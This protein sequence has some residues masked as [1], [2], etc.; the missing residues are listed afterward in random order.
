MP[1]MIYAADAR[2]WIVALIQAQ[3]TGAILEWPQPDFDPGLPG[4]PVVNG[5]GQAGTTLLLRAG[6]PNYAYRV[7]QF[8]SVIHG[9]RRYLQ[10]ITAQA[11]NDATGHASVGVE[12]MIRAPYADG[13]AVEAAK[14]MIEGFLEGNSRD[15]TIDNARLVGLSFKITEAA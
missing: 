3:R 9:G 6:T 1:P 5:A 14:P 2:R 4:V 8:F 10:L 13:S 11:I 12:P 15:W 7:G